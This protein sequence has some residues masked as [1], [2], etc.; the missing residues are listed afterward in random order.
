VVINEQTGYLYIVGASSCNGGLHIVNISDPANPAYVTCHGVNGY[1]HDAQCVVYSG[2]DTRFSG[3]ELC[4]TFNEDHFAIVD[5]TVKTAIYNVA[6][7][8]YA[9]Y[10]YTHQGWLSEDMNYVLMDDELDE[11]M[12]SSGDHRTR[13]LIWN[14][15]NLTMPNLVHH[16][17][18]NQT[19]IGERILPIHLIAMIN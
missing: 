8:S 2:P 14:V 15:Q 13:T 18:S 5:V 4:F 3:K 11:I 17:F 7:V 6:H 16:V 9:G 12:A 10:G 1:V 19:V